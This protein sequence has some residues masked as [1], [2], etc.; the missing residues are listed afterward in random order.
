MPGAHD[1]RPN[2]P[3]DEIERIR[4]WHERAYRELRGR[5]TAE[6]DYL[7]LRL[8]VPHGVF[9]PTPMSDLL[10]RAVRDEVRVADRVLDVGT[11]S[12][13]NAI[14]AAQRA[15]DVLGVDINPLAVACACANAERNGVA[16]RVRIIESDL[17]ERVDG[18]FDLVVCDPPFRWWPARDALEAAITDAG[19]STLR[20]FVG[21]LPARLRPGGR[22]LMFFGT[23]GDLDYLFSLIDEV[24]SRS[25]QFT[26]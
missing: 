24:R 5:Q 18:T 16:E 9:P 1:Y 7:G 3:H 26:A 8:L 11:G 17:F 25:R 13:V 20:R 2:L 22:A 12:G 21:G 19:Y 6:I 10:G 15:R 14:L 4:R 23:S